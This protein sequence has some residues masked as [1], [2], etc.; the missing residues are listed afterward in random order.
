M[1]GQIA[2]RL[3]LRPPETEFERGV[4]RFGYLLTQVMLVMVV[5]VLAVNIFRDKPAFDSLA[6]RAGPGRRADA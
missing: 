2:E 3:K 1:F 5:V 6:L 4:Q